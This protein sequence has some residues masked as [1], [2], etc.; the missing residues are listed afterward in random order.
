MNSPKPLGFATHYI[1]IGGI[2][3]R[4]DTKEI[5]VMQEKTTRFMKTWKFPGGKVESNE[6]LCAGVCREVLEETGVASQ[7]V[8][9]LSLREVQNYQF[10]K[11]DYY[12]VGL[13]QATSYE[14]NFD[15]MEVSAA[16][17]MSVKEFLTQPIAKFGMFKLLSKVMLMLDEPFESILPLL[18]T[19]EDKQN[20]RSGILDKFVLTNQKYTMK[21]PKGRSWVECFHYPALTK[22]NLHDPKL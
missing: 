9:L 17:W 7:F 5:L 6:A 18:E 12:F 21:M 2:V 13:C 15:P 10:G 19:E 11:P 1:G 16:R 3:V 22:T 4:P 14:I 20:K 8:G